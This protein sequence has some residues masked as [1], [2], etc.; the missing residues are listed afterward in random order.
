M[1]HLAA[2]E[3][4]SSLP[5]DR[6][7]RGARRLKLPEAVQDY[8]DEHVE[9]DA[10]HEQLAIRNICGSLVADEPE[11][12]DDV[13]FGAMACLAVDGLAGETLLQRWQ[14]RRAGKVTEET[15]VTRAAG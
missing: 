1:G 13:L 11:L 10:V 4:T 12:A 7:L 8:Y 9:A 5:C 3:A 6:I 15:R 14:Q 2:F